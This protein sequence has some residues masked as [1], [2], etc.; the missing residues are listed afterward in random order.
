MFF[1][2]GILISYSQNTARR[3]VRRFNS[4]PTND[5]DEQMDRVHRVLRTPYRKFARAPVI[6]AR[7]TEFEGRDTIHLFVVVVVGL[8]RIEIRDFSSK[9]RRR[10]GKSGVCK[11]TRATARSSIRLLPAI[12]RRQHT[13]TSQRSDAASNACHWS[14]RLSCGINVLADSFTATIP[15]VSARDNRV[16]RKKIEERH[17]LV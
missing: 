3:S 7:G 5:D 15:G 17:L 13:T 16:K 9:I 11:T 4:T 10:A 6:H 12:N 8:R 14:H 2:V 1:S